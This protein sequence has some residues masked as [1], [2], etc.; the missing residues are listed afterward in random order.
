MEVLLRDV[1]EWD[2]ANWS[3]AVKYWEACAPLHAQPLECM[4]LGAHHGG[5]TLWLASMGHR[6]LCTDLQ[7]VQASASPLIDRYGLSDRVAY[8]ELDAV[9]IPYRE[10][11][12]IIVFKSVLGAVGSNGNFARKRAAF[13]SIYAALKPGG[14]LLF[15]ENLAASPLHCYLRERYVQ[16]GRFWSYADIP[17]M[18]SLLRPFAHVD[19]RTVGFLGAF[20]RSE[21]QRRWLSAFDGSALASRVPEDW[22]YIMYGIATK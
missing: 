9:A 17:E 12:D 13:D 7:G 14:S 22:R 11:F 21:T 18:Q 5:L 6:V 19:Y 3:H 20:G 1:V 16:W 15:A 10:H 2:V 4:E 8:E